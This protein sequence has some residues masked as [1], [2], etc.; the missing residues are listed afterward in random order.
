MW[1]PGHR[2][3]F[4]QLHNLW[5][6]K[7][8]TNKKKF[9]LKLRFFWKIK[10]NCFRMKNYRT[11]SNPEI[12]FFF[13]QIVIIEIGVIFWKRKKKNID[14]KL[15]LMWFMVSS[16]THFVHHK[17]FRI[18]KIHFSWQIER[19][20]LL[21]SSFHLISQFITQFKFDCLS[22]GVDNR[23]TDHTPKTS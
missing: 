5:Y 23:L 9:R 19:F 14:N 6:K 7:Q 11:R 12:V 18:Q 10:R 22:K 2:Q 1:L 4:I 15:Y 21:F 3:I 20:S 17:I 13:H 8:Q 16:G